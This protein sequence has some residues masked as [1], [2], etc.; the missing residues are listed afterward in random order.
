MV[1]V[2]DRQGL[3]HVW[4]EPKYP[5]KGKLLHGAA[6]QSIVHTIVSLLSASYGLSL[7]DAMYGSQRRAET[8]RMAIRHSRAVFTR[9]HS[10]APHVIA[11]RRADSI[12]LWREATSNYRT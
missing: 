6:P 2:G 9:G 3:R 4:L 8:R 5:K 11:K 7:L 12:R 1:V 10:S